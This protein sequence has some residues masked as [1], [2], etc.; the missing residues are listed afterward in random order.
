MLALIGLPGSG[1]STVGRQIARRLGLEFT[2]SDQAIEQRLGKLQSDVRA[3]AEA[4]HVLAA[5][6]EAPPTAESSG[7]EPARAAR[8]A[9]ELLL[10]A[11]L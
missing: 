6:L 8:L 7:D 9:H 10:A 11:G 2:D 4:L 5:G 1:K 3:V